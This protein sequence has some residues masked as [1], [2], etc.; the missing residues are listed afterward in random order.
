[1]PHDTDRTDRDAPVS[2]NTTPHDD[3]LAALAADWPDW[4]LF[5]SKQRKLACAVRRQPLPLKAVNSG[6]CR[7][8]V[9]ETVEQLAAALRE[10]AELDKAAANV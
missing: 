9:E 10:Q 1:M 5:W 6:L 3:P 7:T 2:S 4:G 8:L